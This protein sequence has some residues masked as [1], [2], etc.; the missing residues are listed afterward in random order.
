MT[1]TPPAAL[2]ERPGYAFTQM[3]ETRY[4]NRSVYVGSWAEDVDSGDRYA[5]SLYL[6]DSA[7]GTYSLLLE[8]PCAYPVLLSSVGDYYDVVFTATSD[9]IL[10]YDAATMALVDDLSYETNLNLF[11]AEDHYASAYLIG[12]DETRLALCI[13]RYRR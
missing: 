12:W 13:D 3:E 2:P 8:P 7:T 9:A 11:G 1:D 10:A 6:Y 5:N 4:F